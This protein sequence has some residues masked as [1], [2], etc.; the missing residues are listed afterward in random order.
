MKDHLKENQMEGL[1]DISPMGME[2]EMKEN[3]DR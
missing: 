1:E 3:H 2:E